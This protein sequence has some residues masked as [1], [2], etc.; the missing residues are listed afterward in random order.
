MYNCLNIPSTF[1]L[2]IAEYI[3]EKHLQ[4]NATLKALWISIKKYQSDVSMPS[5]MLHDKCQIT[6][7]AVVINDNKSHSAFQAWT[8]AWKILEFGTAIL[9]LDPFSYS[10]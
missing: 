7:P 9:I 4:Q 6:T 2:F 10:M 3:P 1:L 5:A 8:T